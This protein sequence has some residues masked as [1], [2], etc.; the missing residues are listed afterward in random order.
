L[1]AHILKACSSE[2][3]SNIRLPT[4]P[5]ELEV[6]PHRQESSKALPARNSQRSVQNVFSICSHSALLHELSQVAL[7]STFENVC[8]PG[9]EFS[10][11]SALVYLLY[12]VPLETTFKN[13]RRRGGRTHAC[14]SAR[15]PFAESL[16]SAR[17][18]T[19]SSPGR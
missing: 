13:V 7:K 15:R 14:C 11:L 2:S 6:V 16:C 17:A 10:K 8:A 12:T 4:I 18:P 9:Q 19:H 1:P 5:I 3:P